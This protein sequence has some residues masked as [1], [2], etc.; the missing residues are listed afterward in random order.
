MI[1]SAA[2]LAGGRAQAANLGDAFSNMMNRF[3][4][5]TGYNTSQRN[6]EP[7]VNNI[8]SIALSFLGVIFVVLAIYGGYMW[9]TSQGN[10]TKLTTARELLTAAVIGLIIVVAAYAITFFVIAR[11]T[12]TLLTQ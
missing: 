10:T 3:A 2:L 4:A 7:I 6:V 12:P 1:I 9:M 5:P 8:I 11:V